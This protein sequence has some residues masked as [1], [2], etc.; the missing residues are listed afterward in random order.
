MVSIVLKGIQVPILL[1]KIIQL[2]PFFLVFKYIQM[3]FGL[4]DWRLSFFFSL[5]CFHIVIQPQK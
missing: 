5:V 3:N 4:W 2:M 1:V